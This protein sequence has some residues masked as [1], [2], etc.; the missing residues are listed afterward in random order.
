VSLVRASAGLSLCDLSKLTERL[1]I[2]FAPTGTIRKSPDETGYLA[3]PISREGRPFGTARPLFV[4][5][6]GTGLLDIFD[7][8]SITILEQTCSHRTQLLV[9]SDFLACEQGEHCGRRCSPGVIQQDRILQEQASLLDRIK[10]S[11]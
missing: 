2:P 10:T 7:G 1:G 9:A 4:F 8:D 11:L 5:V 3:L 6:T